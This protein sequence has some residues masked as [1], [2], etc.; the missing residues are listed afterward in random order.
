M[1]SFPDWNCSQ[2]KLGAIAYYGRV[3]LSH[4]ISVLTVLTLLT[5]AEGRLASVTDKIVIWTT[6]HQETKTAER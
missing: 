1:I 6:L 3:C 4:M 5:S 2:D